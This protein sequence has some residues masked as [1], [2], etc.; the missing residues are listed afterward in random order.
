MLKELPPLRVAVLSSRRC[1]GAMDLLTDEDRGVRWEIACALTTEEEFADADLFGAARIPVLS[2]PIRPFYRR[3]G[4][5]LSDLGARAEYDRETAGLLGPHRPDLLLL[6]SYLYV[7]TP[8]L[9]AAAAGWIVNIHGTDLTAEAGSRRYPGLRAVADAVLAGE[10]ETR[11]TAHWVTTEVDDGPPI[12]RSPAFPVAP[13]VR[14]LAGDLR[15]LKAYAYAHQEWML[16]DAWG[17]L[18]LE[19]LRRVVTGRTAPEVEWEAAD[20]VEEA[21]R[22]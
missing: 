8:V 10:S 1:P 7:V 19:V 11:A 22:S 3:R 2:H 17:P 6:S 18:W 16:R 20:A 9:I 13:L 4:E 5:R 15:A 21:A 14:S 12:A